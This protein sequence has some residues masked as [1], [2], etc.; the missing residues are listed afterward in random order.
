[1]VDIVEDIGR[2]LID[3][4]HPRARRRV[5][6]GAGVNGERVEARL[7]LLRHKAVPPGILDG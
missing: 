3:R 7:A 4:R 1:M 5:G 6:L 2:S